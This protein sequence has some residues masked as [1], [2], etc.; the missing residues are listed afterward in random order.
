MTVYGAIT[1]T[2]QDGLRVTVPAGY[3]ARTYY[4][5]SGVRAWTAGVYADGR[6]AIGDESAGAARLIIDLNGKVWFANDANIPGTLEVGTVNASTVNGGTLNGTTVNAGTL[7]VSGNSD[8]AGNLVVHGTVTSSGSGGTG[9]TPITT[10]ASGY[11]MRAGTPGP[12]YMEPWGNLDYGAGYSGPYYF[13]ITPQA[14]LG[15]VSAAAL[16]INHKAQYFMPASVAIVAAAAIKN[17][18]DAWEAVKAVEEPRPGIKDGKPVNFGQEETI[19]LLSDQVMLTVL[20]ALKQAMA[21]IEALELKVQE[22][23]H[24]G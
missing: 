16:W 21:R 7:N 8:I 10:S 5:V 20:K 19:T 9:G 15:T 23:S 2:A 13:N 11:Q 17:I 3:Y 12:F 4:T 24:A 6:Y 14:Q 22:L 1:S 18:P